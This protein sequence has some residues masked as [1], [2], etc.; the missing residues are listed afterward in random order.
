MGSERSLSRRG[1]TRYPN[2]SSKF[3]SLRA[4]FEQGGSADAANGNGPRKRGPSNSDRSH[5]SQDSEAELLRLKEELRQE[6]ELRSVCEKRAAALESELDD[7]N[8]QLE[9]QEDMWREQC[10]REVAE[11][12][13]EAELRMET[14]V[15]EARANRQ[16]A[17]ML[18][19]Q[20]SDL[21][22]EVSTSSRI[23]TQVSDTTFKQDFD[24]L[25][26][27]VQNWVV[28]NYR[29]SRV[30]ASPEELGSRVERFTEPGH[31]RCLLPLYQ[32]F[33]PSIRLPIYQATV[34]CYLM[35]IFEEPYLFGLRGQLGWAKHVRQAAEA[36]P[37]VLDPV[38][39]DRWRTLTFDAIRR[40][41]VATTLADSAARGVAEMVCI[42]LDAMTESDPGEAKIESLAA[43]TKRAVSLAHLVRVQEAQ[44][45]Y[46]L[47]LVGDEYD[48]ETMD[49]VG[50]GEVQEKPIV[51]CATCPAMV[52]IGDLED[53]SG[54]WKTVVM[55]A[56]V[57][58]EQ[59][60]L[61]PE[62]DP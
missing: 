36:L 30:N 57:M 12:K 35:E 42:T 16:E 27:E 7:V 9:E 32:N 33:R 34:A 6:R 59:S 11:A 14:V 43:I 8:S 24:L 1:G 62:L 53:G 46:E 19:K 2:T 13:A 52:K 54:S 15:A 21:K 58:C 20:L 56:K 26:H 61:E 60:E 3:A 22:R 40:S 47:P 23:S 4:A 25:G 29:R 39:Y 48:P 49:D 37:A 18:Q 17:S 55:K 44:Y 50:A 51:R 38:T 31:L 45:E 5:R 28:N 41:E 10:N